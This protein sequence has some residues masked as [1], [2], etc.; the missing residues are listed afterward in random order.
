MRWLLNARSVFVVVLLLLA[1]LGFYLAYAVKPAGTVVSPPATQPTGTHD[2][3]TGASGKAGG[4]VPV[5]PL[6]PLSED[7]TK[8]NAGL[9]L[10]LESLAMPG[11]IYRRLARIPNLFVPEGTPPSAFLPPGP[12]KAT[13]EGD[14]KVDI[15]DDYIFAAEGRGKLKIVI[16]SKAKDGKDGEPAEAYSAASDDFATTVGKKVKLGK[17]KNHFLITYESPEK[18][19][20]IVRLN[21]RSAEI[22]ASDG[23]FPESL[24][25]N[26]LSFD[27]TQA[28][29]REA[30]RVHKG[31]ELFATLRCEAC[32]GGEHIGANL[33]K[34]TMPELTMDAPNLS[35]AGRRL[36]AAWIATWLKNPRA[37]R[38][39]STMPQLLRGPSAE[40]DAEDIAGFLATLGA[41]EEKPEEAPSKEDLEKAG[42]TFTYFGCI[43][44][45][46]LPNTQKQQPG[47]IL[48]AYVRDKWKPAAL[49]EFLHKPDAHYAWIRMPDFRLDDD[50][51]KK[52]STF[53][54]NV[55]IE[56]DGKGDPIPA[57][58]NKPDAAH[59][60]EL[61]ETLGCLNCHNAGPSVANKATGKSFKEVGGSDW[62]H[63]CLAE[64]E[65]GLGKAPNFH[66]SPDQRGALLAFAGTDRTSL[67]RECLPEFAERQ[68]ASMR[69]TVCHNRDGKQSL[70]APE[71][72]DLDA[73]QSKF[74]EPDVAA[75]D[76]A[77]GG[78]EG[79]VRQHIPSLTWIGEKL[80]PEWAA[81][82]VDG[83]MD[84]KPRIW[85][86]ARM[87]GFHSRAA[88]IVKGLAIEH[89]Y[90]TI[91]PPEFKVN[92]E[93]AE[94][95][96]KIAATNGGFAC[97]QCHKIGGDNSRSKQ[98]FEWPS[99]NFKYAKERLL[100]PF[101]N[102][103]MN[104]PVR[105]E[106]GTGMTAFWKGGKNQKEEFFGGDGHKQGEALWHFLQAGR[107]I[108][109]PNPEDEGN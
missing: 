80:K 12:F 7:E 45:H 63:G 50:E 91:N 70:W 98:A 9:S 72:N 34:E 28:P 49:R 58:K 37:L 16:T 79:K 61:V 105:M 48:L 1:I 109:S 71:E 56:D 3:A 76:G 65:D 21:W 36:N 2:T 6:E 40:K 32:H 81:Q 52:I 33:G 51:I 87:P 13:W 67:Q 25:P 90:P 68:V 26:R 18:G 8:N 89:G 14:L 103:W 73:E 64:K 106:P 5:P 77:P 11:V 92:P 82:F 15:K 17:G 94:T 83:K 69:C 88:L 96:A 4:K 35:E 74:K 75:P 47:R 102:K 104:E 44:C 29:F 85:L 10:S 22:D 55:P 39:E 54:L 108:K 42:H 78:G 27:N 41:K 24:S 57:L 84:Y 31:R 107:N 99:I 53:V 100:E 46:V 86:K 43:G 59:G 62:A 93:L 97:A 30:L 20:A 66:L 38:N 101:Y 19:D 95:G 60:K 23:F